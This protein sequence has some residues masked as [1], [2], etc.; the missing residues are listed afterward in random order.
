MPARRQT[1][2]ALPRLSCRR[3]LR[4]RNSVACSSCS[5]FRIGTLPL[6]GLAR[7]LEFGEGLR[8]EMQIEFNA[9]PNEFGNRD[10]AEFGSV[11]KISQAESLNLSLAVARRINFGNIPITRPLEIMQVRGGLGPPPPLWG[12]VW[13]SAQRGPP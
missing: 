13:G 7:V 12:G 4:S 9:V 1:D 2:S 10:V 8:R 3:A 11:T 5:S 6:G